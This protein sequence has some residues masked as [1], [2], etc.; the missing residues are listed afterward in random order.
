M[1]KLRKG[2][3]SPAE[4]LRMIPNPPKLAPVL[5]RVIDKALHPAAERDER[6][7]ALDS[8]LHTVVEVGDTL[9]HSLAK[10]IRYNVARIVEKRV[11]TT[12]KK[13]SS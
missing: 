13:R 7:Y 4:L 5:N 12:R 11:K 6:I 10:T 3:L 8:A 2:E 9:V 1:E